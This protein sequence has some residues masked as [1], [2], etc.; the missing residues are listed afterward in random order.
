MLTVFLI[1]LFLMIYHIVLYP[2]LILCLSKLK[3]QKLY[4]DQLDHYPSITVVCA[5]YNEEEHIRHKIES[6]L[7]LNYPKNKIKMIVI[8][9]DSTDKTN[10]I[11]REYSDRHVELI[12]QKPRKGKQ[13][14][15]N[16]I[17]PF[18]ESDYV[19]STDANS[20]FNENSVIEL[21][22]IIER[23][24]QVGMVSGE[25]RYIKKNSQDSGE[26]I[27]W[28]YECFLKAKESDFLTTIVGAGSIF[29]I[30]TN[31]F[32]VIPESS[33]D[34]FERALICLKHKKLVKYNKEAFIHEYVTERVSDEMK[35]KVRIVTQEWQAVFRNVT[36]FNP[37]KY[38]I[39]S[40][41]LFSHKILRWLIGL[42]YTVSLISVFFIDQFFIG[43]IYL[44]ANIVIL[45]GGFLDLYLEKKGRKMSVLKLFS[46]WVSMVLISLQAN[47]LLIK[48]KKY[49]V[50]TQQR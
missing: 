2:V 25:C 32:T 18:L 9:D 19:L 22:K 42:F 17:L 26:G 43:K 49:T 11:V 39:I 50:W 35:R 21:V 29:L 3:K 7:K 4:N 5:A 41:F 23:E 34:D 13:S 24:P 45:S 1:C 46:Y 12:I 6:F 37:F 31:L 30:R 27:Y 48:K 40:F 38:G 8:S 20:I 36:L 15:H 14:A 33:A 10:E 44:L 28:K 16:M 47:Y